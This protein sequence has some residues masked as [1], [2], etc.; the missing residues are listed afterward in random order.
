LRAPRQPGPAPRV[1]E[2]RF[3]RADV[4]AHD[5]MGKDGSIWVTYRDGVYDVTKYVSEHPG[6]Q[7]LLQGAGGPVEGFWAQWG[8]H[9]MSEKVQQALEKLRIGRLSDY[10]PEPDEERRGGGAWEEEQLD[11]CRIQNR[12][13]TSRYCEMPYV[14][15]TKSAAM[16]L[17]YLTP[18]EA[19]YVRNH[20][21]VP[22]IDPKDADS[23]VVT[24]TCGGEEVASPT[25][26]Q[27]VAKYESVSTTSVL[28]CSGNRGADNIAAN[29]VRASGFVGGPFEHIGL[30][31]LGNACWGG[32]RLSDVVRELFPK[33][34]SEDVLDSLH[35]T[36]EGLDGYSTST[37]LRYV[38]DPANDCLLATHMN[39][40][41]LPPDHGFPAR[42]VLPGI[43]GARQV[44]WVSNITVGPECS[45]AWNA[46]Y[47]KDGAGGG[48]LQRLPMNSVILAPQPGWLVGTRATE[49]QLSG[50]AYGGGTGS[51]I[52][53]VEVS[54]DR[55]KSWQPARCL[56]E[57]AS[58]RGNVSKF[59]WVRFEARVELEAEGVGSVA[60]GHGGPLTELWCRASNEAGEQQPDVSGS[61]GG[62]FYNGYHRVPIVR[63]ME[64]PASREHSSE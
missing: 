16:I 22:Y 36:F 15:E 2:P 40:S 48:A 8:A 23:H 61:H 14:S 55:G 20:A 46:N 1:K 25:L 64:R 3:T 33:S 6:G 12:L 53:S 17:S 19:F 26:G 62:Y 59:G 54:A 56:F 11:A 5:G 50:V 60:A 29:G 47:Y 38:L 9:H 13:L 18:N 42:A 24:F 44:K 49:V 58:S 43:T 10:A 57:E 28:Q 63:L 30:G 52:A 37:P 32:V 41:P 21:P 39:G 27:L 45:S 34:C 51:P 35:V 4:A 7:L 31:L